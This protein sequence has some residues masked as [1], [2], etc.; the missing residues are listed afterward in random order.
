MQEIQELLRQLRLNGMADSY[1]ARNKEALSNQ[2]SFAEFMLLLLEDEKLYRDQK[3]YERR[4]KKAEFRGVKTLDNFDFKVNPKID[5][6]IIRDLATC[7]YIRQSYPV[8]IE[9]PCG[10]GKT[11]I[12]QALGH[13]A[14]RVGYEVLF[15]TQS[16]LIDTL[17]GAKATNN[18]AT[19]IKKFTKVDLLIIDEFGLKPMKI[20]E[21]ECIHEI[22]AERYELKSTIITSNLSIDEYH[23]A[24]TN[25][26]LAVATVDRLRHD[27][28]KV[29]L[30]GKSY[31]SLKNINSNK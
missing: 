7:H 27:A 8:I 18:Y 16:K 13:C 14:L 4:Y 28:Y 15:I 23:Q 6:K 17:N 30:S 21:D 26:L 9:G 24:F 20:D 11:H 2:L 12:A 29:V 31:R 22:I 10:I 5:Q 19:T 3:Q 25:K 1:D